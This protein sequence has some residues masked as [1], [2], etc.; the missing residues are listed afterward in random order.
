[1]TGLQDVD[2]Q[3]EQKVAD[4]A[5][6][7]TYKEGREAIGQTAGMFQAG[8]LP[9]TAMEMLGQGTAWAPKVAEPAGG[10]AMAPTD[11]ESTLPA[12]SK[13]A[14]EFAEGLTPEQKKAM[15]HPKSSLSFEQRQAL[16]SQ[17]YGLKN[18]VKTEDL[19][20]EVQTM[21]LGAHI[22]AQLD[23]LIKKREALLDPMVSMGITENPYNSP[24]GDEL[25]QI[26]SKILQL[27]KSPGRA[28][29]P[30]GPARAG[31]KPKKVS[32]KG[33]MPTADEIADQYYSK[34][35]A[36]GGTPTPEGLKSYFYKVTKGK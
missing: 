1:M 3:R 24:V 21:G 31:K 26:D 13:R 20:R 32:I 30:G 22:K 28:P 17:E 10:P 33:A 19:K 8:G 9:G 12:F 7:R 16:K 2:I 18:W 35:E 14:G 15:A 23:T 34:I 25:K 4:L 29:K 5:E 11:V 6:G 36:A 27:M